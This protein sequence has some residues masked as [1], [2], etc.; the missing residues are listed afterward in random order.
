LYINYRLKSVA[1]MPW[2]TFA[3]KALST[4]IDDLFSWVMKMP[5]LHRLAT[6]RDDVVFVVYLYQR[7]IYRVD[8]TRA[9]EYGQVGEEAKAA[10]TTEAKDS[11]AAES[12]KEK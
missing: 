1:H 12:K 10:D 8:H 3:Y 2:R 11:D 9:N 6:L 7:W 4:F 5:W